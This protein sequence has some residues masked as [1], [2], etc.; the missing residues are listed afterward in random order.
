MRTR[1]KI[2]CIAGTGEAHA[3]IDAGADALGLVSAMPSG[4]GVIAE[5]LIA[6]I[7]AAAPP[8][9][10]TFLLTSEVEPAAIVAQQRRCG[11]NTLQLC[12]ALEA[13]AYPVLR[14]ALPGIALV[15]VIHVR[16][17]DAVAEARRV[18]PLVDGLLLDSG[19]P[20][21]R[22]KELGGTGRVH[23]W[24][25]SRRIVADAPCPVF[26]AGGLNAGNVADAIR[27]VR[28]FGVDL[29]TGV[30]SDGALDGD[31]LAAFMAA[32]ADADRGAATD[33]P[34]DLG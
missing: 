19:N 28:P 13:G 34:P 32:V 11:V 9:V 26:L 10:G 1:V 21:A 6:G 14:Q 31:R 5:D 24:R 33:N 16:G 18:A 20:G 29:C 27:R 8:A 12:D 7:A 23:D 4:P 17:E 2:C 3:A 15:Q 22:V 25:L 30:R